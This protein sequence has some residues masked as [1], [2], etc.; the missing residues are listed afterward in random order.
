MTAPFNLRPGARDA[1]VVIVLVG[2]F[3][4]VAARSLRLPAPWPDEVNDPSYGMEL[5]LG[6]PRSPS[7]WQFSLGAKT[8]PLRVQHP[9]DFSALSIY[10]SAAAFRLGGVSVEVLRASELAVGVGMLAVFYALCRLWFSWEIGLWA[11]LLL[12]L[13]PAF[14]IWSRVCYYVIELPLAFLNLSALLLVALWHRGR[15]P[16]LLYAGCF[17]WAFSLN[18]TTKALAFL[19]AYPV[20]FVLWVPR[21]SWPSRRQAGTAAVFAVF[22]AVNPIAYSAVRGMPIIKKLMIALWAPTQAGVDNAALL[23]NIFIRVQQLRDVL[24]GVIPLDHAA[25]GLLAAP[26]LSGLVL[27]AMLAL[28]LRGDLRRR[29]VGF[30]LSL[31]GLLFM[32]TAFTPTSHDARHVMVLWPYPLLAAALGLAALREE[33]DARFSSRW[34]ALKLG[35]GTLAAWLLLAAALVSSA[36]VDAAYFSGLR[37]PGSRGLW[38]EA[39][40]DVARHLDE[41]APRRLI[42]LNWGLERD[43]YFLTHGRVKPE[44]VYNDFPQASDRHPFYR[45]R[46]FDT[47]HAYLAYFGDYGRDAVTVGNNL[48]SFQKLAGDAGRRLLT[49]RIFRTGAGDPFCG[50]WRVEPR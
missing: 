17:V 38:S 23:P 27:A 47:N 45:K 39:V 33:I 44:A 26:I 36:R 19:L 14:V 46:F 5:A 29:K 15:R 40:Y 22:G 13:N 6:L 35:P 31:M 24:S 1:A 3:L 43:I 32:Q 4:C 41:R 28:V 49:E 16:A 30:V 10:W 42:S 34:S 7:D 8:W 20:L 12:A 25:P 50:V 18:L 2:L 37:D 48:S 21:R 9:Y 11:G